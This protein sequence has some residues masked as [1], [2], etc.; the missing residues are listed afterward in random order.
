MLQLEDQRINMAKQSFINSGQPGIPV[1]KFGNATVDPTKNVLDLVEAAVRRID[2]LRAAETKRVD[3][4]LELR[5]QRFDQLMNLR[6]EHSEE[7]M[8]LRSVHSSELMAAEAKRIDA[9]RVVDV[10]A[11]ATANE[12]A[13]AQATVLAN[14]VAASAETLRALVATT[15]STAAT[16]FQ[17]VT[18][19]LTDR[20]ASLEKSQYEG[21]GKQAVAD[22]QLVQLLS[23]VRNLTASRDTGTGKSQGSNQMWLYLVGGAGIVGTIIT[24]I[25]FLS[26]HV[27]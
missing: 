23:E 16:Q 24:V 25:V 14:Q 15:A 6:A 1:D 21:Q 18:Q 4:V 7:M 26:G 12:K 11:V 5:S 27:H 10:Q 2:D 9:I 22:P 17:Q 20:I 3:E 19:Q 13:G 8:K